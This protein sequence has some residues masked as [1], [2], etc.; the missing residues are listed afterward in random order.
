MNMNVGR[1]EQVTHAHTQIGR[2]EPEK[3]FQAEHQKINKSFCLLWAGH[4]PV[5]IP[6]FHF[7]TFRKLPDHVS[8]VRLFPRDSSCDASQIVHLCICTHTHDKDGRTKA[9]IGLHTSPSWLKT[10]PKRA[11][12]S[13]GDA[14]PGEWARERFTV[15]ITSVKISIPKLIEV[16]FL[17]KGNKVKVKGKVVPVLN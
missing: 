8:W 7:F 17:I 13:D 4:R 11:H 14:I 5:V 9:E 2:T 6:L 3:L 16:P 15:I 1:K 12:S 10:S